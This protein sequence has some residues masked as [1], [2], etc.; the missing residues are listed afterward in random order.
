MSLPQQQAIE[1]YRVHLRRLSKALP[2][3]EQSHPTI[4]LVAVHP[5]TAPA[6]R[7]KHP[8]PPRPTARRPGRWQLWSAS[9]SPAARTACKSS[10]TCAVRGSGAPSARPAAS[11]FARSLWCRSTRK[12]GRVSPASICGA[13]G[14]QDRAP[15]RPAPN[16][17]D[18]GRRVHA[19]SSDQRQRFRH[20]CKVEPNDDLVRQLRDV[21]R[22]HIAA[23][24]DRATQAAQQRQRLGE[25]SRRPTHHDR[26]GPV[27]RLR[28]AAAHR[29]IQ[30]TQ[31]R[32]RR[33]P[34]PF[35]AIL[36]DRSN[37]CR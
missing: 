1:A 31:S 10:S 8:S 14:L 26:H 13:F 22:A 20:R 37:S 28:F 30:E 34:R 21:P 5:H 36:S 23:V 11:A 25:V 15:C 6:R 7:L 24:D 3:A 29:G 17:L 16:R 19:R 4:I 2:C 27:N 35:R 9:P 12:P 32:R 18:H 33:S